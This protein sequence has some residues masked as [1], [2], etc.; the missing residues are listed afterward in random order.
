MEGGEGE[1]YVRMRGWFEEGCQVTCRG[2]VV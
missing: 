1:V 2:A